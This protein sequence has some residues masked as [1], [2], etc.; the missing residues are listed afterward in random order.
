LLIIVHLKVNFSD[1]DVSIHYPAGRPKES[2]MI[3]VED[4]GIRI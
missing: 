1:V 2:E 3:W 4:E